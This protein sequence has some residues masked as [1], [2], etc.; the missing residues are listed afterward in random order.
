LDGLVGEIEEGLAAVSVQENVETESAL[1]SGVLRASID[2]GG[3]RE[4]VGRSA[5]FEA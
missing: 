4:L 1:G 3:G 5:D 2:A